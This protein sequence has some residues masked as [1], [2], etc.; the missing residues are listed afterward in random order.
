[1]GKVEDMR[2][3]L[4]SDA[5][6]WDSAL[7]ACNVRATCAR[8]IATA[9]GAPFDDKRPDQVSAAAV[10]VVVARD[11]HGSD[12]PEPHIWLASI[13]KAKG[14]G[15]DALRLAVA[16]EMSSVAGKHSHAIDTDEDARAFLADVAAAIPGACNTYAALGEGKP[17]GSLLLDETPDHS[18]CVQHDLSRKDG[19][20]PTYGEGLFRAVAGALALW[21]AELAALHE[22]SALMD[23]RPKAALEARLI[24]LDDATPKILPKTVSAP[25]GNVWSQ[26]R[27]Q[28][29]TSLAPD[30]GR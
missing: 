11:H 18:P 9:I 22:G 5:V 16:L 3:A 25:A 19:P 23:G 14:S 10:A 13:G 28:H 30:A 26:T 21:K 20:G 24:A 17:E 4:A 27:T 8:D 1:M 15:A 6:R 29:D 7:P 12:V 2:D